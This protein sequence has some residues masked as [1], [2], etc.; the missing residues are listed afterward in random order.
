MRRAFPVWKVFPYVAAQFAGSIIASLFVCFLSGQSDLV[1]R[2]DS[3]L[4]WQRFFA[5]LLASFVLML[6]ILGTAHKHKITGS[7]AA[8]AVAFAVLAGHI[9]AEPISGAG[10]NPART[11][12]PAIVSGNFSDWWIYLF[13]PSLGACIAVIVI[14][15]LQG[16]CNHD[17]RVSAE[18]TDAH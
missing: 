16:A 2:H 9:I 4:M 13:A 11:L 8:I 12:G 7:N 15:I 14:S 10:M 1:S 18:G 5:E 6:V 3:F 17:E